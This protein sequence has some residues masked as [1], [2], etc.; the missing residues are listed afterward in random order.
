MLYCNL[1]VFFVLKLQYKNILIPQN[2]SYEGA[3]RGLIKNF[4]GSLWLAIFYRF[5]A[6]S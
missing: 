2:V 3:L 6:P 4:L 1:Q 5:T